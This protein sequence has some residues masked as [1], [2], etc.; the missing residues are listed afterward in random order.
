MDKNNKNIPGKWD[1]WLIREQLNQRKKRRERRWNRKIEKELENEK[2][3]KNV[4]LTTETFIFAKTSDIVNNNY[5]NNKNNIFSNISVS[6]E[7]FLDKLNKLQVKILYFIVIGEKKSK[8][9]NI[10]RN[11]KIEPVI[12]VEQINKISF[13]YGG[14]NIL[15]INKHD[16]IQ[17][18]DS[19]NIDLDKLLINMLK[20]NINIIKMTFK[21]ER[22]IGIL[23]ITKN[24]C[25]IK[26][27]NFISWKGK[28][29]KYDIR[30]WVK[31]Y[32]NY[33]EGIILS[34]KELKVL[35]DLLNS[36]DI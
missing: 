10:L 31:G 1:A 23:S 34:K 2:K 24:E 13:T 33:G 30:I 7:K 16:G 3:Q 35:K 29:A 11:Y 14:F 5:G 6:L 32:L 18:T 25:Y 28:R 27:L 17:I 4:D 15:K 19:Y 20:D 8:V 36:M 12:F 22:K 9:Y 26:E 21:M